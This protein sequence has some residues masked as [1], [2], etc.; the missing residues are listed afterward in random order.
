VPERQR[1]WTFAQVKAFRRESVKPKA[2][3]NA[4]EIYPVAR[5]PLLPLGERE[6][7][8]LRLFASP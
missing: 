2:Q 5:N 3:W 7:D 1:P 4:A 8:L 6:T